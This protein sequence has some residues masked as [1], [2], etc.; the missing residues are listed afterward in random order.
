MKT[1]IVAV[2]PAK[3]DSRRL[4]NKNMAL[5]MGKPLLYYTIQAARECPLLDKVYVSTDSSEIA[6]F[7][8]EAGVEA[9]MRP[10]ELCAEAPLLEVYRH[11][12]TAMQDGVNFILG[13]QPDH[14]DRT[15]KLEQVVRYCLEK[16]LDELISVDK[17]GKRNGSL[18]W[19]KASSL[20]EGK[21]S[22][23]CATLMDEATN[24]HSAADLK[25]AEA[26]IRQ[27]VKPLSM[28]IKNKIISVAS[29]AFVIAEGACNHMCDMKLAKRMID[30][31]DTAG[32]DAIKFQTYKAERL[33]VEDAA[34]YWDY[35]SV[36]SQYEYYKKLDKFD[37]K[38]YRELFDYA[39][40]KEIVVF[41]SPFDAQSADMLNEL[42]VPLFKVASCLIP[43]K[44][45]IRRIAGFHKPL[46]ISCGASTLAEIKSA[47]EAVY[48]EDNYELVL[49]A[50]T[51]SYPTDN[52]NAHLLRI[53][54]LAELFPEAII[55]Y[56]DHTPPDENMII[57]ALAVAMGAKVVEKHFTLDRAMSGSGHAFSV[58]PPL[59]KKMIENIRLSEE[60]LGS[61]DL[62]V[63][64]AEEKTRSSARM[65]ILAA[66][67]IKKGEVIKE[68]MLIFR[69]PGTGISVADI[70]RVV[71][72]T[73]KRDIAANEFLGWDSL[74]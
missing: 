53:R 58:D 31:A 16:D 24:I 22:V 5:L 56:S 46:I 52:A 71:G 4:P 33:V 35:A 18:R 8:K 43:D 28:K 2:I 42:G 10:K 19:L 65:S 29:P 64:P 41:S 62:G 21:I 45:L 70:E 63:R 17:Q 32:A 72:K 27:R 49:M 30:E 55:G 74:A 36:K 39:G 50:C 44:K 60:T 20:R 51:L 48:A 66:R 12:L 15:A 73:A 54:K 61:G 67:A 40:E 34:V 23:N 9:I 47:V 25:L 6:S 7:A 14:P 69:R 59:L 1:G 26:R 57:P 13:L 11:A 68:E 38:E 37:R 3:S